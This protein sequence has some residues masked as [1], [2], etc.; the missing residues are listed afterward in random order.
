MFPNTTDVTIKLLKFRLVRLNTKQRTAVNTRG[1][2][3]SPLSNIHPRIKIILIGL[4]LK[5][6]L[7]F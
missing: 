7:M 6:L 4:S 1:V 5:I 2:T 3:S